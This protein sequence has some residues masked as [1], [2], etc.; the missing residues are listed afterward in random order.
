MTALRLLLAD[1]RAIECSATQWPELFAAA[2]CGLGC[3]GIIT[4]VTLQLEPAFRLRES[5]QT[6]PLDRVLD[7]LPALRHSCEH[8]K[9][10]WYPYT[11]DAIV[12]SLNR[13]TDVRPAHT[14]ARLLACPHGDCA[15]CL[16]FVVYTQPIEAPAISW[17]HDRVVNHVAL[18]SL[19]YLASFRPSLVPAINRLYY[20]LQWGARKGTRVGNSVEVFNFDCLFK[21]H[22][23]EWAIPR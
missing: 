18:E 15:A 1:G 5:W 17:F 16:L 7:D 11:N 13:T 3:L 9:F 23:S 8:F 2:R 6:L 21:Q 12:I 4:A 19:L 20:H 10:L 14:P 22:V